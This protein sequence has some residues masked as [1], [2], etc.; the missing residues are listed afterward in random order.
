MMLAVRLWTLL[1]LLECP[2]RKLGTQFNSKL[3]N[4][5][6]YDI[7]VTKHKVGVHNVIHNMSTWRCGLMDKAFDFGSRD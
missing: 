5:S 7:C 6:L 3:W 1:R 4:D 2:S